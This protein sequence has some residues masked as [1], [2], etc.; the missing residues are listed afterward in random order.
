VRKTNVVQRG[1]FWVLSQ[2]LLLL[3]QR[4]IDMRYAICHRQ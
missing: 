3:V 4:N 1:G 2:G